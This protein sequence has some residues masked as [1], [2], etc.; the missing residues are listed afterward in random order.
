MM[1]ITLGSGSTVF[2]DASDLICKNTSAGRGVL[3]AGLGIFV[4]PFF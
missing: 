1:L 2:I 4:S 3:R